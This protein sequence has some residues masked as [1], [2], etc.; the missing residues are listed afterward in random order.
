MV[1]VTTEGMSWE[2]GRERESPRKT[3]WCLER[4]SLREDLSS[5]DQP[6]PQQ[7]SLIQSPDQSCYSL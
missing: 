5:E 1:V 3:G 4:V 7:A 6:G 2:V